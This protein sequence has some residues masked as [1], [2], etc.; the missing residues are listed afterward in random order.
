MRDITKAQAMNKEQRRRRATIG[1]IAP[2]VLPPL[3]RSGP[4]LQPEEGD[5]FVTG[6]FDA[7]HC[8]DAL[9]AG[10]TPDRVSLVVGALALDTVAAWG[11]GDRDLL[12]AAAGLNIIATGG[13]LDLDAAGRARAGVLAAS[14]RAIAGLRDRDDLPTASR[15]SHFS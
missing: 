12:D 13:S 3:R 10:E 5:M 8:L 1:A 4:D 14:V 11:G 15:A 6:L 7:A 2:F 9:A